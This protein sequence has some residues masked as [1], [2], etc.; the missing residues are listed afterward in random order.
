MYLCPS[1]D[2]RRQTETMSTPT[3]QLRIR[4]QNKENYLD[5]KRQLQYFVVAFYE[6]ETKCAMQN[7]YKNLISRNNRNAL[8]LKL[9]HKKKHPAVQTG[10]QPKHVPA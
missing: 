9:V 10:Q 2:I 6:N 8:H 5:D 4:I 1:E 7:Y 3:I